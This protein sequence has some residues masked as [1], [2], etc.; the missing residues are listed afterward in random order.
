MSDI[1]PTTSK[2]WYT[3]FRKYFILASKYIV[4][5][6][7]WKEGPNRAAYHNFE[8]ETRARFIF[9]SNNIEREGLTLGQTKEL[10]LSGLKELLDQRKVQPFK[11]KNESELSRIGESIKKLLPVNYSSFLIQDDLTRDIDE[12]SEELK[13]QKTYI[14]IVNFGQ[15]IK[16]TVTVANHFVAT[17]HA[18]RIAMDS[19]WSRHDIK[20]YNFI[21]KLLN[22]DDQKEKE[23]ALEGMELFYPDSK[24]PEYK[25]LLSEEIIKKLHKLMARDLIDPKYSPAG[26]Y[27][28]HSIMTDFESNFPAPEAVPDGMKLFIK[29][30]CEFERKNLNPI[31]LASWAS[32][33]FVLIHPFSDFNGRMSRLIMNMVL[34]SHN[35]PFW[36]SMRSSKVERKRYFTALRHYHAGK[37]LSIATLIAIQITNNFENFN[38]VLSLSGYPN[39]PIENIKEPPPEMID[40]RLFRT[41]FYI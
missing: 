22:S 28:T 29:Q 19:F 26:E 41:S 40:P 23:K 20:H 24:K 6:E 37:R 12:L 4:A 1:D 31:A 2:P 36:V 5:F 3:Q 39:V 30:F 9:E 35:M 18:E 8:N 25:Q 38:K 7:T 13:N 32:T 15:N 11:I 16:G 10:V 14:G 33:Q 17:I 34:K 27:R 21:Q